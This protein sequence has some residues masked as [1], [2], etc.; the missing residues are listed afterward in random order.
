MNQL[1]PRGLKA[2]LEG[3]LESSGRNSRLTHNRLYPG[4]RA[5]ATWRTCPR[6]SRNPPALGRLWISLG[7]NLLPDIKT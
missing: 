7:A 5:A 4:R 6:H 1:N 3:P 2:V